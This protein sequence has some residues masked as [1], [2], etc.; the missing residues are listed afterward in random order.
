ML[1][2]V[3]ISGLESI[4]RCV[5]RKKKESDGKGKDVE[6]F[7]LLVE[8]DDLLGVLTQQGVDATATTA[9]HTLQV[10]KTLGIEA[11]RRSI[12]DEIMY[13]MSS[14]GVGTHLELADHNSCGTN[15]LFAI[16]GGDP[17]HLHLLAD[18]MTYK[19]E[20]LGITRFG[21]SKMKVRQ[22]N[23]PVLSFEAKPNHGNYRIAFSCWRPSSVLQI[24]YLMLDKEP[25]KSPLQ[26]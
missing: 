20:V 21:I 18:C 13:T 7:S 19:G 26:V 9:N 24:T 15:G 1:P 3:V 25:C 16:L 8:G 14:H 5:I 4:N 22:R 23:L 17:R 10:F 12:V 6:K 11:A 2:K